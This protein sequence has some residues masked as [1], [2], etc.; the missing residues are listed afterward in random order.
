MNLFILCGIPGS[1][2]STWAEKF[3][4]DTMGVA[5]V[6]TDQIRLACYGVEYDAKINSE[7]FKTAYSNIEFFLR[8]GENVCLDATNLHAKYR[9]DV[10][11]I[12]QSYSAKVIAIKFPISVS[13]ALKRIEDRERKVPADVIIQ[14][15]N[16]FEHPRYEEG[17]N[18]IWSVARNTVILDI[19]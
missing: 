6:S 17:I 7:V 5:I 14:M 12:A 18:K 19:Y 9:Q 11:K 1:G 16:T 8:R 4:R 3:L 13:T 15:Y 2:K 10:I